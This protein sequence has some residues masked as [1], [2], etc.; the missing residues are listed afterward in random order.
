[1]IKKRKVRSRE[2]V[3]R[4]TNNIKKKVSFVALRDII[5]YELKGDMIRRQEITLKKKKVCRKTGRNCHNAVIY[6]LVD[7]DDDVCLQV[8]I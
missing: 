4:K 5:I 7:D 2:N 1:M 3:T 6:S 8:Y